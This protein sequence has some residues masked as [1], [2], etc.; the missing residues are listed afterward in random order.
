MEG[1]RQ[2]DQACYEE[3][4]R[5][6]HINEEKLRNDN[7][8]LQVSLKRSGDETRCSAIALHISF[9]ICLIWVCLMYSLPCTPGTLCLSGSGTEKARHLYVLRAEATSA[10]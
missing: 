4:C 1:A 9:S 10:L 8:H 6:F 7:S 3:R 2:Q 5:D